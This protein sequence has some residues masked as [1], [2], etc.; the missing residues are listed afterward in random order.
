M[1]HKYFD[2]YKLIVNQEKSVIKTLSDKE[3][4]F[5][6]EEEVEQAHG[7]KTKFFLIKLKIV[8]RFTLQNAKYSREQLSIIQ[9]RIK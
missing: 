8:N 7:N 6:S 5:C 1:K 2:S 3:K 4:N 9:K